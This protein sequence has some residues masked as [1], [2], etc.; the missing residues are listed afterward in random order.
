MRQLATTC[1]LSVYDRSYFSFLIFSRS[2][3][4]Y[5]IE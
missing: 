2:L 1:Y 4:R 5:T 3:F